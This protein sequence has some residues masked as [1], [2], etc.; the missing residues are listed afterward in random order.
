MAK[1]NEHG[2]LIAA[3]AKS[4]L[5]PLGCRRVGQSR[6]WYSD[7]R[8]WAI[9]I[10]F[11]PSSWSK[12]SYLNVGATW[13]WYPKQHWTFDVGHRI[14]EAGLIPFE[15]AEQFAPLIAGMA[16]RAAQEVLAL[17]NKFS[18][19]DAIH[20]YLS[21]HPARDGTPVYHAAVA[22][23]LAGDVK[24]ARQFFE[25]LEAWPDQTEEWR[26]RVKSRGIAL[27]RLVNK[28]HEFRA[29]ILAIIEDVR[30]RLR[31]PPVHLCLES[32]D[33]IGAK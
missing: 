13:L 10:E 1:Q 20:H 24:I 2:R 18:T 16:V 27:A 33:S 23:A 22:A 9:A 28:P 29:A 12:G 14:E 15:N 25:R 11:Q 7:Q 17:R 5:T 21:R 8:Y 32:T 4:A 3:A 26:L 31:L 19:L 6:F 30:I